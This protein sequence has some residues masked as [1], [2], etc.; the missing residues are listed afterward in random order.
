MFSFTFS[1]SAQ[2]W[3]GVASIPWSDSVR[4][5][6]LCSARSKGLHIDVH[7]RTAGCKCRKALAIHRLVHALNSWCFAQKVLPAEGIA[8]SR[9]FKGLKPEGGFFRYLPSSQPSECGQQHT[10]ISVHAQTAAWKQSNGNS[11]A[12]MSEKCGEWR[13]LFIMTL[14]RSIG[15]QCKIRIK[16]TVWEV[17]GRENHFKWL[18]PSR[19]PNHQ[20]WEY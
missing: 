4:N 17:R 6:D 9:P 5:T 7:I 8:A 15:S 16:D 13:D 18:S 10:L 20:S 11:E 2:V 12:R 19:I 1:R 3:P 14:S